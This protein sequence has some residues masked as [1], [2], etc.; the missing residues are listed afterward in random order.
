MVVAGTGSVHGVYMS[1][2]V[3]ITVQYSETPCEHAEMLYP[4]GDIKVWED[5]TLALCVDGNVIV[6]EYQN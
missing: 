2:T 1:R 6:P 5:S 3:S 4:D